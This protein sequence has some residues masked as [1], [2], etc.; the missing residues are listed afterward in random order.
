MGIP[1]PPTA[2][3]VIEEGSDGKP[4]FSPVWLQ[5]FL[6]IGQLVG[7][8]SNLPVQVITPGGSPYTL[9]NTASYHALVLVSGGA[10][11]QTAMSRDNSTYYVTGSATNA[12]AA[13]LSPGDYVQVTYSAAPAV[14]VFPT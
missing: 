8:G 12:I 5:W 14:V 13:Y 1:P 10:V 11:S 4:T 2:F 3:P 6:T 7:G 9:H